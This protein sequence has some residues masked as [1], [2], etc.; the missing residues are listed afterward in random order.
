L[1]EA[2]S[3]HILTKFQLYHYILSR[4]LLTEA[5]SEHTLTKFCTSLRDTVFCV[6]FGVDKLRGFSI[7]GEGVE[8]LASPTEMAGEPYN[9]AALPVMQKAF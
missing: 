1:T 6:N 5:P 8:I 9:S 7:R 4:I 3:E 2:P